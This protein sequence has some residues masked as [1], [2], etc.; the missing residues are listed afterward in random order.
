MSYDYLKENAHKFLENAQHLFRNGVYNLSAFNIEQAIQMYLKYFLAVKLGEF[1]KTHS[2]KRLFMEI[3]DLCLEAY[4]IF[5][6]N[7][8]TFGDIE[9]AY[10]TSR[11][12]P[13]EFLEKEISQ[14]LGVADEV[15]RA[16]ENC[17]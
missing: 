15:R 4:N 13:T 16:I 1:P 12:F 2:L 6:E 3:K 8:G 5:E 10:I 11:Y 17:L 14:M 9:S 7:I